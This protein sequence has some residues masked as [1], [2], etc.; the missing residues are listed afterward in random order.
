MLAHV[1]GE[2]AG[3][4][5]VAAADGKADRQIDGLALVELLDALGADGQGGQGDEGEGGR[6]AGAFP[7]PNASAV[8]PGRQSYSVGTGIVDQSRR[9][10]SEARG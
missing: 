9:S 10:A 2:M 3:V 8:T 7:T 4:E 5:V 1:A 6:Q